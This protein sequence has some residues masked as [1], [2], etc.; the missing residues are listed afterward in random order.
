M[1]DENVES[2]LEREAKRA[3]D[4]W[5]DWVSK[6]DTI[7]SS[8]F[9]GLFKST[10]VC[11]ECSY[12]SVTYEP[13]MYLTVPI[14]RVSTKNICEY[15][16]SYE[17]KQLFN[18]VLISGVTFVNMRDQR[19]LKVHVT[20]MLDATVERLKEF[21]AKEVPGLSN[22]PSTLQDCVIVEIVNN[23]IARKL[24]IQNASNFFLYK[25]SGV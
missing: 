20:L 23:N 25:L 6:N 12:V 19:P 16:F 4:Y 2:A 13:F 8:T 3:E 15:I 14:P 18:L 21:V 11:E 7:I 1:S 9:Q 24:V 10:V 17:G 22:D 5:S